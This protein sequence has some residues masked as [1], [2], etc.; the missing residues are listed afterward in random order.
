M[1][2]AEQLQQQ[3]R[4]QRHAKRRK[5]DSKLRMRHLQLMPLLHVAGFLNVWLPS[6]SLSSNNAYPATA[7]TAADP[8]VWKRMVLYAQRLSLFLSKMMEMTRLPHEHAF[9]ACIYIRRLMHFNPSFV[10]LLRQKSG[11]ELRITT[12]ALMLATKALSDNAYANTSFA[13]VSGFPAHE[14]SQMELEFLSSIRFSLYVSRREYR[15]WLRVL[16]SAAVECAECFPI[17]HSVTNALISALNEADSEDALLP[18]TPSLSDS[19]SFFNIHG[20]IAAAGA[21]LPPLRQPSPSF[22]IASSDVGIDSTNTSDILSY[23]QQHHTSRDNLLQHRSSFASTLSSSGAP[24]SPAPQPLQA[25][26]WRLPQPPFVPY[27]AGAAATAADPRASSLRWEPSAALR[28]SSPVHNT[29]STSSSAPI[30]ALPSLHSMSHSNPSMSSVVTTHSITTHNEPYRFAQPAPPSASRH[31]SNHLQ[32]QPAAADSSSQSLYANP[33]ANFR[34]SAFET[35]RQATPTAPSLPS[36]QLPAGG[37]GSG[38]TSPIYPREQLLPREQAY[39]TTSTVS[40]LVQDTIV[41]RR[42]PI[43]FRGTAYDFNKNLSMLSPTATAQHPRHTELSEACDSD[44]V[45]FDPYEQ[46]QSLPLAMTQTRSAVTAANTTT[47]RPSA[48]AAIHEPNL[49]FA[50]HMDLAELM[51]LLSRKSSSSGSDPKSD[52]SLLSA[53]A[54]GYAVPYAAYAA[55]HPAKPLL[56]ATVAVSSGL[57]MAAAALAATTPVH[58]SPAQPMETSPAPEQQQQQS[59]MYSQESWLPIFQPLTPLD[60]HFSKMGFDDWVSLS[61]LPSLDTQRSGF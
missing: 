4:R 36:A 9:L 60:E 20:P 18:M 7:A 54:S 10:H 22:S 21:P 8:E 61:R 53:P 11:S 15:Q 51:A 35:G 3:R 14:L 27:T 37:Y 52:A 12:V 49:D 19:S 40:S 1:P 25:Q 29:S 6:S 17:S 16:H 41:P 42:K 13:T 32:Q 5:A 50:D 28:T 55:A 45:S 39:A 2:S 23:T 30:L 57:P 46:S 31:T 56:D 48:L 59:E 47:A 33:N 44:P 58:Y 26:Q 38:V 34:Y 24:P 43:P